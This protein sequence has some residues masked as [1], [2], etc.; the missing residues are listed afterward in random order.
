MTFCISKI[1]LYTVIYISFLHPNFVAV[2]P[3]TTL[4][5][6]SIF[7]LCS[8][9]WSVNVNFATSI[10]VSSKLTLNRHTDIYIDRIFILYNM[11]PSVTFEYTEKIMYKKYGKDSLSISQ[12]NTHFKDLNFKVLPQTLESSIKSEEITNI[13]SYVLTLQSFHSGILAIAQS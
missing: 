6:Y 4:L 5:L 13:T 10:N 11:D 12:I 7:C 2:I 8:N 1:Y 9:T 3:P